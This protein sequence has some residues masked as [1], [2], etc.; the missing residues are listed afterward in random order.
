MEENKSKDKNQE[1]AKSTKEIFH[2]FKKPQSFIDTKKIIIFIACIA[3]GVIAGFLLSQTSSSTGGLL[4]SKSGNNS[5]SVSKGAI[6]GS[7]DLGTFKD[8]ATGVMASGGID[9]EG[10]FHLVRPG[11]DSQSVYLTSSIVDLSQF[12]GKKV[13]VNG[14]TQAAKKAGWLMDVG[15]VEV[16]E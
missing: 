15:R 16:L 6:V 1:S 8:S 11:G 9:G 13:K 14:Q 2:Q 10:Q 4:V 7:N 12:I 3:V 5:S